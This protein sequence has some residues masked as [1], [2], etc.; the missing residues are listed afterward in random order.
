M[1]KERK[2]TQSQKSNK[3]KGQPEQKK[4]AD[5]PED[6]TYRIGILP[7]RDLKKNLGCG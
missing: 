5:K 1:K 3:Q 4:S 2:N 6:E 7:D